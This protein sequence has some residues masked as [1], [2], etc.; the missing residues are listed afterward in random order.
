M[1]IAF[2]LSAALLLASGLASI[3][4]VDAQCSGSGSSLMATYHSAG[5]G[6]SRTRYACCPSGGC[7]P[8]GRRLMSVEWLNSTDELEVSAGRR[9]L[10]DCSGAPS[11][12]CNDP[13]VGCINYNGCCLGTGTF[14]D[15]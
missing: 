1:R 12:G 2:F 7:T 6:I 15:C 10:Q 5:N 3:Q 9:L 13:A 14:A 4:Q 8:P 11:Y